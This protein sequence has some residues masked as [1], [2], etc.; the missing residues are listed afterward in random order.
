MI[1]IEIGRFSRY[2]QDG[3]VAEQFVDLTDLIGDRRD[4]FVE[5][6]WAPYI[7]DGGIYAIESALTAS[8]YYYQPAIFEA[9]GLEPPTTWEEFLEIGSTLGQEGTALSVMTNEPQ[10]P[11]SM[12]F[13]QRG[14]NFF[15]PD[16]EFVLGE[17][18]NRELALEVLY[19]IRQALDDGAF[20]SV[21]NTDF[22]GSTIPTAFREGSLAGIIMPDWYAGCCLKP[23]VEGMA[24]EWRVAPMP[25]WEDGGH[26][27]TVWGGTGFAITQ[28]SEHADLVWSL[29]EHSYLTLEGQLARFEQIGFYP[30]M[31]EALEHPRITE[32]EDPFFGGQAV[33]QVFAEVALDTPAVYQ[34]VGRP[35]LLQA[36]ADNLPLFFD[37]SVT[38]DQFLDTVIRITEDEIAF[39]Q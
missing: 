36:L 19:V 9:Q 39:S 17:P 26:T 11:F 8:A 24:G 7:Y 27:T 38:A 34:S 4:D 28:A 37:G 12:M 31:Y 18:E 15:S 13:L 6:R 1:G 10:G 35:F 22:W 30:T 32:L 20:Y 29:L 33:G 2:L 5:G 16:G 25:V 23:G 3:I 21:A 14:G